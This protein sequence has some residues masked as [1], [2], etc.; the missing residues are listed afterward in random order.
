MVNYIDLALLR[1]FDHR[2]SFEKLNLLKKQS[3]LDSF[4]RYHVSDLLCLLVWTNFEYK[5]KNTN[6]KSKAL[7]N[8]VSR[9]DQFTVQK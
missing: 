1:N 3:L 2:D 9:R 8:L 7:T 5:Y 4:I 6:A